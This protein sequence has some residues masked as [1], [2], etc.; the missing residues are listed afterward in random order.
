MGSLFAF[1]KKFPRISM[2]KLK[3]GV[4]DGPWMRELM[5]NPMFDEALS[6]AKLSTGQ[7][8]KSVVTNF[9]G[10]HRSAE[11]EKETEEFPSNRGTNVSQT[12]LSMVTLGLFSKEL[13]RF[14]WRAGWVPSPRHSHYGSAL[15]KPVGCRRSRWLLLVLKTRC[16]NCRVQEKVHEKAFHSW[17]ASFVHFL[18][19]YDTMWTS[20][21]SISL[22]FRIICLIQQENRYL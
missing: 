9:L 12:A 13:W 1:R 20:Y 18:V 16:S 21:K 2:D 11:Y 8:P 4:F 6:E 15:P 3:A 5:K 17:I 14:E 19:Y 7:L 10:N 22:K